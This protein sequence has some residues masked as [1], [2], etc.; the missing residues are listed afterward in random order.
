MESGLQKLSIQEKEDAEFVIST[1]DIQREEINY[2]LC[3][4]GKPVGERAINAEALERTLLSMWRPKRG[5]YIKLMIDNNLYIIQFYHH[6]DMKKMLAGGSWSFNKCILLVHQWKEGENPAD[7]D[8][9]NTD[10]WVQFH[11]LPLGFTSEMLAKNIGNLMGTYLEYD[12][13]HRHSS[14]NS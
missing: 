14:W 5:V 10:I 4:L 13:V 2:E 8:F 6:F 1:E 12:T 7:V 3:L 9:I 11:G